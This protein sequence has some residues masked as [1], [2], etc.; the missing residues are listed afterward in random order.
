MMK[1]LVIVSAAVALAGPAAAGTIS[2]TISQ[3]A[4][5]QG[6]NLIV[7]VKVGNSGDEAAL[8]VTPVLRFGDKEV[9]GKGKAS[10]EPK[11]SLDETLTLPVG[12]LGEG[13][14]PYRLA[15]DYTDQNQYPFQALQTQ[16]AITGNPQPAKVAVPAIKSEEIS[17]TGTLTVTVKN[18]TPDQ[19]TAKVSVLVPEGLEA[20]RPVHEVTLDGWKEESVSFP[21]TNRTALVG[22]RYPV[23]VTAEYDDGAVHQ[24]VVAQ[25]IVSVVGVDSFFDRNARTLRSGAIALIVGWLLWTV[26]KMGRR[27]DGTRP[28]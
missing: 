4:R 17:G 2:I 15:V 20:S 10:L 13:R 3:A 19:R 28:A 14:W 18:L 21:V 16:A 7:D 5:I 22:S 11:T 23:F 27:R 8:S 24:A 26:W 25:S 6:E 1:G 9:R 12:P